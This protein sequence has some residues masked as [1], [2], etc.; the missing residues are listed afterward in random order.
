M[1][2]AVEVLEAL[3]T[4]PICS[5]NFVK[6]GDVICNPHDVVPGCVVVTTL[7]GAA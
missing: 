5:I 1:A 2:S 6:G 4:S 3:E 7:S